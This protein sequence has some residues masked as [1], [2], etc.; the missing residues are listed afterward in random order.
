ML[1]GALG[2]W[3]VM[4]QA[5]T[6][7]GVAD[8]SVAGQRAN[9]ALTQ[10]TY[11]ALGARF[12]RGLRFQARELDAAR[13]LLSRQAA[14][15]AT[16]GERDRQRREIHDSVLQVL[17]TVAGGWTVSPELLQRRINFE[18]RRL[19]R[20][21]RVVE[22]DTS[23]TLQSALAD[24]CE[25]CEFLGLTVALRHRNLDSVVGG[26]SIEALRDAAREALMNT[27]KHANTDVATIDAEMS[28]ESIRVVV[29]DGGR[30]FDTTAPRLGFGLSHSVIGRMNEVDGTATVDSTPR[31]GTIVTLVAPRRSHRD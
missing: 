25:E 20:V 7:G 17:E 9:E 14:L 3:L 16:A 6:G 26:P 21:M 5:T 19:E 23:P 30:G 10:M 13:E 15:I 29:S 12:A 18:I 28:D 24:L 22:D 2:Q 11:V 27:Y 8:L 1:A 4:Y 31:Q